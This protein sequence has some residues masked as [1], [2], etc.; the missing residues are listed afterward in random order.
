MSILLVEQT[1]AEEITDLC[2]RMYIIEDGRIVSEFS[3][4][5]VSSTDNIK[6]ILSGE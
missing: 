4:E 6:K 3:K 2:H 1:I 5:E